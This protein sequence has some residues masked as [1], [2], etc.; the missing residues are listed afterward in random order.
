MNITFVQQRPGSRIPRIIRAMTERGHTCRVLS[1]EGLWAAEDCCDH[2]EPWVDKDDV[3]N[4]VYQDRWTQVYHVSQCFDTEWLAT[5]VL[6]A[7][8]L[9]GDKRQRVLWDV[10][11]MGSLTARQLWRGYDR[12]PSPLVSLASRWEQWNVWRVDGMVHVSD[13]CQSHTALTY[14]GVEYRP[15]CVVRNMVG[16]WQLSDLTPAED[17][18]GVVYSGGCSDPGRGSTRDYAD[19]LQHL[20]QGLDPVCL[21]SAR[22]EPGPVEEAY[23]ALG[24]QVFPRA[25]QEDL[26][27]SL[28]RFRW[29]LVGFPLSYPL[30]EAAGPN[31]L[32]EYLA[33]GVVPIVVNCRSAQE[34]VE[35]EGVGIGADRSRCRSTQEQVADILS[36]MT[37]ETW[38]R[39]HARI[40]EQRRKWV[41]EEE[42]IRY[43]SML[44]EVC[45]KPQRFGSAMCP[46]D[47]MWDPWLDE[48]KEV[49]ACLTGA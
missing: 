14:P 43:E 16:R 40:M 17:R 27:A 36:R 35:Q 12:E 45:R 23:R 7:R 41:M 1:R 47:G 6:F 31:K 28:S 24:V 19:I 32:W 39:C 9:A 26:V 38:E 15:W 2:L 4:Y 49:E 34:F 22:F 42:V 30:G 33:A 21:Q 8:N 48:R 20:Q 29:G 5:L 25:S 13:A 44:R 3:A 11:D 10:R 18:E 46:T 37:Q